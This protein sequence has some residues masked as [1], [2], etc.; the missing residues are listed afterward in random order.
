MVAYYS[1]A[2]LSHAYTRAP[3]NPHTGVQET[4]RIVVFPLSLRAGIKTFRGRR[5][6]HLDSQRFCIDRAAIADSLYEAG[7]LRR[8]TDTLILTPRPVGFDE[9]PERVTDW[10]QVFSEC[11]AAYLSQEPAEWPFP[12]TFPE[13]P[14]AG[15]SMT[16]YLVGLVVSSSSQD[17]S[18][19]LYTSQWPDDHTLDRWQEQMDRILVDACDDAS[20]ET[21]VPGAAWVIETTRA[22]MDVYQ[23][24]IGMIRESRLP[25]MEAGWRAGHYLMLVGKQRVAVVFL[26]SPEGCRHECQV[27]IPRYLS[28]HPTSDLIHSVMHLWIPKLLS[29]EYEAPS[30][31]AAVVLQ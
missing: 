20:L 17:D 29:Q 14:E 30:T 28:V 22:Q 5:D 2:V 18:P 12:T 21:L 6:S 25:V 9:L 4:A 16:V 24:V 7:V 8:D 27:V 23:A 15:D 13:F 11:Y 26:V 10:A 19:P 31:Q 1:Y 3:T